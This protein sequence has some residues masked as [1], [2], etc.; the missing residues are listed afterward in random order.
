M[1]GG[2]CLDGTLALRK[3]EEEEKRGCGNAWKRLERA[4][5]IQVVIPVSFGQKE[6]CQE[7]T[8]ETEVVN[9]AALSLYQNLGFFRDKK[10]QRYYLNGGD[11]FRLKYILPHRQQ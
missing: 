2:V 1:G 5:F 6:G 8:L 10:L 11:A 7:V 9:K 3:A 4:G